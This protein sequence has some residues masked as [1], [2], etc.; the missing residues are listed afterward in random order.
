MGARQYDARLGRWIS[1]DTIIPD[2]ANPQTF[3]RYAYVYNNPVV[4]VDPDGHKGRPLHD[5][6]GG[7]LLDESALPPPIPREALSSDLSDSDYRFV[8]ATRHAYALYWSDPL[9]YS[10]NHLVWDYARCYIALSAYDGKH[11]DY[12][13]P[14]YDPGD[15][16]EEEFWNAVLANSPELLEIVI[17]VA[18]MVSGKAG[19][20]PPPLSQGVDDVEMRHLPS[21][22]EMTA[23]DIIRWIGD[24]AQVIYNDHGDII[25]VSADNTRKFRCDFNHTDP[26]Q[27]EHMHLSWVDENGKWQ[28]KR[29]W[30][31]DVDQR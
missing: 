27:N 1:A 5:H 18:A 19:P 14:Y 8:E 3:N 29:I 17:M 20:L 4:Y 7:G 24:G 10:K 21:A 13:M 15:I 12:T 25:I 22:A 2:P 28:T 6:D 23:D 30:P 16:S 11:H 26:H 31:S 9:K